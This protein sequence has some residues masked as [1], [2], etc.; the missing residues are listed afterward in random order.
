MIAHKQI[1]NNYL[2]VIKTHGYQD[3]QSCVSGQE[4]HKTYS[5]LF[6]GTEQKVADFNPL[7]LLNYLE[8][9]YQLYTYFMF[10]IYITLHNKLER[11]WVVV[12]KIYTSK[13]WPIFFTFFFSFF[14]F[15]IFEPHKNNLPM[16]QFLSNLA[17]Q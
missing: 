15:R 3:T 9:F 11:N 6:T 17:H 7:Y 12:C 13:N 10:Y 5:M 16:V 4:R 2:A 8:D 1:N 14:F